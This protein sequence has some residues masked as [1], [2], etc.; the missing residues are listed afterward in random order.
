[1]G[2]IA[3]KLKL[4]LFVDGIELPVI[5]ARCTFTEGAPATAEIQIIATD[6]AHDIP[7]RSFVNLFYYDN[8]DFDTDVSSGTK[9]VRKLGPHD[10]RRYKLMFTG[11]VAGIGFQKSGS[12]RAAT[13]QCIDCTSYLDFI[14]Q[15]YVNFSNGGIELFEN[16]FM[17]VRLD[18]TQN[19]DVVTKGAQS[20][21]YVWLTAQT[22]ASGEPN[23]YG[24]VHRVIRESFFSANYFYAR[25]YNRVRFGDT[26][27][28]I[29][30]DSTAGE[31][32][33]L[34]FFEKFIKNQVGG[35]GGWVAARS[36][37]NALLGPV[38]HTYVTVPCPYFDLQGR[39]L[40]IGDPEEEG[41]YSSEVVGRS[42]YPGSSLNTHVIK[43]DTWF[44]APPNCNVIFPHMYDQ[45]SFSRNYLAEP[46]RIFLRS[47]LLFNGKNDKWLTERLYGPDF[48][49]FN[50]QFH[51]A[52]GYLKRMASQLMAH[53]DHVGLNPIEVWQSELAA[54]VQDG[55]RREYLARLT[56][57][58]YWK[59]RFGTRQLSVSMPF[60]PDIIPG[61]P[62]VVMDRVGSSFE[63]QLNEEGEPNRV[64][65][66]YTG[67]VASVVH[68]LN[69]SGAR[70]F[71]TFLGAR[72]HDET[73][74]FDFKG[75][76]LE[77]VTQRGTDGFLDDR[78]DNS[79]IGS[80][81][82]DVL[83]GC[84]SITDALDE[85]GIS[86]DLAGELQTEFN[87]IFKDTK[88][89][90]ITKSIDYLQVL[91]R[92]AVREGMDINLFA[93]S[94][95]N[96]PKANLLQMLGKPLLLGLSEEEASSISTAFDDDPSLGEYGFFATATD[97]T[98]PDTSLENTKYVARKGVTV[99][100]PPVAE[101]GTGRTDLSP[102]TKT[103]FENSEGN[104][105]L[106]EHLE[107]R[108]KLVKKYLNSLR[109][110]G[111]RG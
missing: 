71:A 51:S 106:K 39:A 14:K 89:G 91:Y 40:G 34:Q 66:H 36:M 49:E 60:N 58:L 43:P 27:V 104:Y 54:F 48:E 18:R 6:E 42:A 61:Y 32:F 64:S 105:K 103:V 20:N 23:L 109:F 41:S 17:G 68:S 98:A 35:K 88:R 11:E 63:S 47:K 95:T 9:S 45:I 92:T 62:G 83:F 102:K 1:M 97:P 79:R 52:G 100:V 76:S 70:T 93:K 24:G 80:E 37:I 107:A 38:F 96:R 94:V 99:S 65:R 3:E 15:H 90:G 53:E 85:Q 84:G 26:V 75:R 25:A 69:Q 30:E 101:A 12:S 87:R 74:D 108:Q 77:E 73:A 19:F 78:Y 57:Y 81:V 10:L 86:E 21:L 50:K 4:R 46:T 44:L 59:Y 2:L 31:L 16:A 110:R 111:L 5:G 55:P 29:K 33:D 67:N 13:L 7:A 28:G 8:H 56:D 82:Y 22:N 72:V